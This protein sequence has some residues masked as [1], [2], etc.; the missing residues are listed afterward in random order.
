MARSSIALAR[1][2][3]PIPLLL[4]LFATCAALVGGA[5]SAAADAPEEAHGN[6]APRLQINGGGALH[7]TSA[8]PTITGVGSPGGPHAE[9]RL[10]VIISGTPDAG[11]SVS[12]VACAGATATGQGGWSCKVATPLATGS[13]LITVQQHV[14]KD[15]ERTVNTTTARLRVDLPVKHSEPEPPPAP[16]QP[17]APQEPPVPLEPPRQTAAPSSPPPAPALA[18]V[19][20]D[21]L[22]WSFVLV[23]ASGRPLAN[24]PLRA[25]QSFSAI[26][27]GLPEGA[28]VHVELH[29]DPL[30]LVD[31]V[32]DSTGSLTAP[33][34]LPE[35]APPGGH[36][37]VATLT[38]EGFET[39][40]AS[41][42][43]TVVPAIV[44]T[45]VLAD[46]PEAPQPVI[47]PAA[48]E[49]TSHLADR[50]IPFSL[51]EI[52]GWSIAATGGLAV[53]FVLLAALPAELLQS[54]LTENYGRAFAWMAPARKR[55]TR[56][57]SLVP[58]ALDNPWVGSAFSVGATALIL[59]FSEPQFGFNSWSI[60]TF[61]ALYLS[62]YLLNVALNSVKLSYA[63]R[64]LS[65]DG[66]LSPL[67]GGMIIAAVSVLASRA[68]E[69]SPSLL[70][71][72][73]VGVTLARQQS[74][75][76]EGRLALVGAGSML[77]L[78]VMSWLGLSALLGI[79]GGSDIFIV[80]LLE[81][82]L[83]ATSLEALTVL[84]VGLLPFEYLEGK[85][86]HDWDQRIWA[87]AY[88]IAAGAFVFIAVPL[89]TSWES[90]ELSVLRW[91]AIC[92]G[93]AVISVAAWFLFR[94]M[95]EHR[96]RSEDRESVDA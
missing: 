1:G 96:R 16:Q 88:F 90:T 30:P 95:P 52:T 12:G 55:V 87:A 85:A 75:E 15:G 63:R 77:V 92:A 21:L 6:A 45:R 71:G 23:D 37:I 14:G 89:G 31:S 17:P 58:P 74:R 72:L 94:V 36:E 50:L 59:G 61:L 13:Y 2:F 76:A 18:P 68:L 81:D 56:I 80:G 29:S 83:A 53:I 25:G 78:G 4:V 64:R 19:T 40:V 33:F 20:L 41:I 11:G 70:F 39:S 91:V 34:T 26:A 9:A 42:G 48:E 54:T 38:A 86:L 7:V 27:S 44:E 66:R 49:E 24:A 82:T 73:V 65:V 79:T 57:R 62:L 28:Q 51:R 22:E 93:F 35:T 46:L 3:A 60:R 32:V 69:L 67:P 5:A 47:E 43:V 84:L 8:T 10:S